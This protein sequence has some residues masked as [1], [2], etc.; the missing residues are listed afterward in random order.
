[1]LCRN[2]ATIGESETAFLKLRNGDVGIAAVCGGRR[3]MIAINERHA[4]FAK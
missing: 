4:C 1:M 3:A 2:A